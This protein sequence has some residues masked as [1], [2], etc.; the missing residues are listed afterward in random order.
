MQLSELP[1]I[2]ILQAEDFTV[3]D[4]IFRNFGVGIQIGRLGSDFGSGDSEGQFKRLKFVNCSRAGM[5]TGSFNSLDHH[6]WD[7]EFHGCYIAVTNKYSISVSNASTDCAGNFVILRSSFNGSISSYVYIQ[8]T[9]FF[10]VIEC[11]S[12]NSKILIYLL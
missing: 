12:L 2:G 4:S 9:G 6:F 11:V 7:C 8:N 10:G 5:S 1:I 3:T